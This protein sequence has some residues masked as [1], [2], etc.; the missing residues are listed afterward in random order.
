MMRKGTSR[1]NRRVEIIKFSKEISPRVSKGPHK[2]VER[3]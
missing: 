3:A 2:T 1:G